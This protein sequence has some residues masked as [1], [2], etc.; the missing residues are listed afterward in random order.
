M[1][2]SHY[3]I[4]IRGDAH[5]AMGLLALVGIQNIASKQDPTGRLTARLSSE[6]AEGAQ[7]RVLPVSV[8]AVGAGRG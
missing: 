8:A 6:S 7:G 1:A 5:R 3:L 2:M 4:D